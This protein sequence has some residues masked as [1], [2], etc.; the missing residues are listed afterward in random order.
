M[1]HGSSRGLP[2]AS[3]HV[4]IQPGALGDSAIGL[5]GV[6]IVLDA[7]FGQVDI[8]D[9]RHDRYGTRADPDG[10]LELPSQTLTPTV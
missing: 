10:T 1:S 2:A 4:R 3:A 9:P 7:A 5:G 8:R 6:A